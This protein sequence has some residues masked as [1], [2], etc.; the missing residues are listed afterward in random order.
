MMGDQIIN[1]RK[2]QT[3]DPSSSTSD[4]EKC[5]FEELERRREM[6][7]RKLEARTH[8]EE[9]GLFDWFDGMFDGSANCYVKGYPAFGEKCASTASPYIRSPVPAIPILCRLSH[10]Y[11]SS[12]LCHALSYLM[13]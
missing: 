12:M 5:S 8:L 9:R 3:T 10:Y 13:F 6:W 1:P 7:K 4:T 2:A 11:C